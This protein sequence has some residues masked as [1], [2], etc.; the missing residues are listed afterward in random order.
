MTAQLPPYR[1]LIAIIAVCLVACGDAPDDNAKN[2]DHPREA[3][4]IYRDVYGTPGICRS[5]TMASFLAMAM[6][7]PAIVCFRWKCSSARPKAGVAEVLG[8]EFLDLDI[9]LR[10]EYNHATVAEQVA[11]LS[12]RDREVL[13]GYA[14]GFNARLEELSQQPGEPLPKP[15]YDYGFSP[16]P[17]TAL[18]V[19]AIFVGSIAHRYADFN[20]E[21]DNLAFLRAME[22][23]HGAAQGWALF[24]SVKWLLDNTSPTTVPRKAP[25]NLAAPDRPSYLDEETALSPLARIVT[26]AGGRFAGLSNTEVGQGR[27]RRQLAESG[28]GLHSDFAPASNYWAVKDL[29]DAKGALLNGPQFGFAMPSYVY[30]IGLH[31]GDF[32]V[33]GNTLLALPAL[34][35]AHNNHIAWGST[36]GISDQTDEFWLRLNPDN[37]EQYWH[38][39]AWRDFD[40][41]PEQIAVAG[42]ESVTVMARRSVHGMVLAHDPARGIAWPGLGPG[43]VLRCRI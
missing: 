16:S 38:Q 23:R 27:L 17:W 1:I 4:T 41:W 15:F 42:A 35:F 12:Q 26:D 40:S 43:R 3:I 25:V 8:P 36:A 24:N 7:W 37:P 6:R 22:Q 30:G 34:L 28:Y 39:G 32:D 21:R 11:A 10:T 14:A 9:K 29:D 33:V 19:A 31:G 18:D 2:Q 13:A 20:S 5:P